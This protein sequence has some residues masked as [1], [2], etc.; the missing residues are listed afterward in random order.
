MP[1]LAASTT[2]PFERAPAANGATVTAAEDE[3]F[4]GSWSRNADEALAVLFRTVPATAAGSSVVTIEALAVAPTA[5]EVKVTVRLLP[6]PPHTP[7]GASQEEKVRPAGSVSFSVTVG[8]AAP[9]LF[10]T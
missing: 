2:L 1:S 5:S 4:E 9:D 3:L 8:A 7:P 6:D 10:V